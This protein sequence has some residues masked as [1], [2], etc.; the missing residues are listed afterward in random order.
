MATV[1]LQGEGTEP[2]QIVEVEKDSFAHKKLLL[3]G[4][5]EVK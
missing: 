4:W 2:N 5:V 3:R 1:K